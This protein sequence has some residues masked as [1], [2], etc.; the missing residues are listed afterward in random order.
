MYRAVLQRVNISSQT[1]RIIGFLLSITGYALLT[2]WQAISYDPCTE[3]SPFHHP[4]LFQTQ[5]I[6][7][8]ES[9]DSNSS[10]NMSS[11]FLL[12]IFSSVDLEFSDGKKL[13]FII[14]LGCTTFVGKT[15]FVVKITMTGSLF[16]SNTIIL[17]IL[18]LVSWTPR[19]R[20]LIKVFPVFKPTIQEANKCFVLI[21]FKIK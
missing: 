7:S 15:P 20:Y 3:Y 16:L 8:N 1:I 17:V 11:K 5:G 18:L 6:L 21:Y 4:K 9:N 19:M 10:T 12:N 14:P 2:D 13:E